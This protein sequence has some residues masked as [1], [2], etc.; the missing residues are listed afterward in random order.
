MSTQQTAETRFVDVDGTKFAYRRFGRSSDVPLVF[1]MHFRGTM[2]HWDPAL[3]NRVAEQR[4][5]FL[6]D[7]S[8]VGK[9]GG[10]IPETYSGWADNVIRI[11]LVI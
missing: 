4:T 7:N 2:D 8:G 5:I 11:L 9:S 1:L 3:I 10:E 6:L